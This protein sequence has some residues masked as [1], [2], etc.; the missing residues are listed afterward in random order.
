MTLSSAFKY[1]P[2]V[3]AFAYGKAALA[4][5]LGLLLCAPMAAATFSAIPDN[6]A[7][8]SSTTPRSPISLPK[9]GAGK[10]ITLFTHGDTVL[11]L[12][13]DDGSLNGYSISLF[14]CAF[15]ILGRD[16]AIERAPLSRAA[17]I[18]TSVENAVWFPSAFAGD[19]DRLARSVGP[20]GQLRIFWYLLKHSKLDPTSE[21]FRK[22]ARVTAYKGSALERRL[23]AENYVFQTGSADRNRLVAMVLS[24]QVDAL[25]AVDFRGRLSKETLMVM[26]DNI[27]I[28]LFEKLPVAFQISHALH[29]NE[30]DFADK[31]RSATNI[32]RGDLAKKFP[33]D[34][35]QDN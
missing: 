7:E 10:K 18:L 15:K 1:R 9:G 22:T 23:R 34:R 5:V 30:P 14:R 26:D 3:P 27:K 19:E 2:V 12:R 8:L 21:S 24:G 6:S 16:F 4:S 33:N 32:C 35:L 28:S 31:F 13:E 17:S 20:A 11:A 25:L 29:Q